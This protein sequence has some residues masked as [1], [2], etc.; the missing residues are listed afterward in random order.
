MEGYEKTGNG[1]HRAGFGQRVEHLGSS[2]QEFWTEARD[3][4]TDMTQTLDLSGRVQRHPYAMIAAA[5]G[6]GYVL[7][8]GLF[9]S[10]T[11]RVVRLGL[12][13]AALPLVKDELIGLAEAAVDGLSSSSGRAPP[14]GSSG[15]I[16][17]V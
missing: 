4:V 9:T 3:M 2:A 12:R 8:G 5:A 7:G 10:L 15:P 6:I 14:S 1:A 17:P 16:G 13:L 11:A